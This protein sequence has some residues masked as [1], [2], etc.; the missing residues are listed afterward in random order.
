M[1][2]ASAGADAVGSGKTMLMDLMFAAAPISRK[3]RVHFQNFM[4]DVHDRIHVFR[5]RVKRG[6]VKD[7]DPIPPVAAALAAETGFAWV[8]PTLDRYVDWQQTERLTRL[9]LPT[10]ELSDAEQSQ[11]A[12]LEAQA[13]ERVG[14][15]ED[16]E[17]SDADR[18][19]AE[20]ALEA[21]EAGSVEAAQ[22]EEPVR[23][24]F[25]CYVFLGTLLEIILSHLDSAILGGGAAPPA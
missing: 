5:G 14:V 3:R 2:L 19:T 4:A 11:V 15:L 24:A 8:R 13:A 18:A 12:D 25:M 20:T 17:S 16:E 21:L 9:D 6:E 7:A 1:T 22:L 23:R 10:P